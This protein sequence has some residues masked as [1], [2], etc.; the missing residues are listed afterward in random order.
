MTLFSV[1]LPTPISPQTDST[2]SDGAP[3]SNPSAFRQLILIERVVLSHGSPRLELRTVAS[4]YHFVRDK[5]AVGALCMVHVPTHAQLVD[6][7]TKALSGPKFPLAI[8][9]M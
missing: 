4:D 1:A 7:F 8:F 5:V 3:L 6:V 2:I 9:N